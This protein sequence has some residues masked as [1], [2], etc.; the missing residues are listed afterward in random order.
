[1][2]FGISLLAAGTWRRMTPMIGQEDA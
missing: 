2:E 1:L